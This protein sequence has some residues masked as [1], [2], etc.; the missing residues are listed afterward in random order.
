MHISLVLIGAG[1]MCL[2]FMLGS[3]VTIANINT[4]NKNKR[5]ELTHND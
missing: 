4:Y 1:I 2:G 3:A 5:R